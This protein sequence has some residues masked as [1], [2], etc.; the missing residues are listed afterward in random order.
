MAGFQSKPPVSSG[1][2]TFL[3]PLAPRT[4]GRGSGL[5]GVLSGLLGPHKNRPAQIRHIQP[6]API[7]PN[8]SPAIPGRSP[9]LS[10]PTPP[11][12]S[13]RAP[14]LW[15]S[16][17]NPTLPKF[18]FPFTSWGA[19]LP[20]HRPAFHALPAWRALAPHRHRHGFRLTPPLILWRPHR[21]SRAGQPP[22]LP[23]ASTSRFLPALRFMLPR[24]NLRTTDPPLSR[25]RFS[26]QWAIAGGRGH[27]P[28][29]A[30]L[31]SSAAV[32]S[33]RIH[34]V[35]SLPFCSSS[36]WFKQGAGFP[37]GC[38]REV[39]LF[40]RRLPRPR[41]AASNPPSPS[42]RRAGSKP[43]PPAA[44]PRYM[45]MPASRKLYHPLQPPGQAPPRPLLGSRIDALLRDENAPA[46]KTFIIGGQPGPP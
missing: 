20:R 2:L 21:R 38:F 39:M 43:F 24:F 7:M 36:S 44:F 30:H 12:S 9:R 41:R 8:A 17:R 29:H 33:G 37:T 31:A 10:S 42:T 40:L 26:S 15:H 4:R 27:P 13:A 46:S 34:P 25:N 1:K 35:P 22:P 19:P 11:A 23:R 5:R 16:G 18:F 32:G 45:R 3:P 28:G 6:R 14:M